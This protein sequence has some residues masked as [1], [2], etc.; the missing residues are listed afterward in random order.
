MF[1][2]FPTK[3][4][5]GFGDGGLIATPYNEIGEKLKLLR[6]H[7]QKIKYLN[8][9]LGYNSRLDELQASVLNVKL[10]FL[11]VW[12]ERRRQIAERYN[13]AFSGIEGIGVPEIYEKSKPVYHLYTIRHSERD[14]L[15]N[16]LRSKG[17]ET[18]IYYFKPLHLQPGLSYLGY[19][20]GDLPITELLC[21]SVLSL[22]MSTDLEEDEVSYII[23]TIMSF[24]G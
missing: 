19:K 22:P 24:G 7:G 23:D 9:T 16:Y 6:F 21:E 3:N 17:I 13:I 5:G 12:N 15:A 20:K 14:K 1:F 4:L 18:G 11:N 10:P 8:E 2:I